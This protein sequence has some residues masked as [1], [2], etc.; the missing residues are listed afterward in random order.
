RLHHEGARYLRLTAPRVSK[1]APGEAKGSWSKRKRRNNANIFAGLAERNLPFS[2]QH[3]SSPIVRRS[4]ALLLPHIYLRRPQRLG[5]SHLFLS[6]HRP[7]KPLHQ[8]RRRRI[9]HS[10]QTRHHSFGP[11]V[12]EAAREAHQPLTPDRFPKPCL[13]GREHYQLRRQVEII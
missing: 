6:Q 13:A 3:K 1:R 7:V 5:W 4:P 2:V 10:P 12:H 9:L 11:R 8:L